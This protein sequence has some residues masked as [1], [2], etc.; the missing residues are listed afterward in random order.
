MTVRTKSNDAHAVKIPLRWLTLFGAIGAVSGG[1][2]SYGIKEG[3][4][5]QRLLR[6]EEIIANHSEL[7][8][9]QARTIHSIEVNTARIATKQ[10]AF[11]GA[12]ERIEAKQERILDKLDAP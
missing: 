8:A 1:A 6:D 10:I 9:G 12:V 5:D 2:I 4:N 11:E 7:I 3:A